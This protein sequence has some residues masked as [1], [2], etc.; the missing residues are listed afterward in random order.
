[1]VMYSRPTGKP[2]DKWLCIHIQLGSPKIRETMKIVDGNH[3]VNENCVTL[4]MINKL[5]MCL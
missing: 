5:C 2:N 4:V 1:M 3:N